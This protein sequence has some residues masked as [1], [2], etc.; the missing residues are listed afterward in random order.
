MHPVIKIVTFLLFGAAVAFGNVT[1]LG[2]G[3]ALLLV[4]Y[5]AGPA[6][7]LRLALR[8]LR[9]M[10]WFFLSIAV[11]YLLF[12]PGRLLFS[13]WPWGPTLEGLSG[14]GLRIGSLVLI[15]LAVN[16]LLRTTLRPALTSAILW[17]LGPLA[18]LGLP[19]ERVAV[20]IALTLDAIDSVQLIYR[21][22]PRDGESIDEPP[23]DLQP[24][25]LKERLW[26]IGATAQR[27]VAAV[28]E[29][30]ESVPVQSIEVPRPSNPPLWQW[31]YPLLLG[32]LFAVLRGQVSW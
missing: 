27:L 23:V 26:R 1:A 28:I 3:S 29:Q 12:T 15:V 14:G 24:K 21:H 6:E 32:T 13:Q 30:A 2:A 22:R 9:R 25:G 5:L 31:L 20:R 11:V 18:W 19:R 8:M 7:H 17:C 10:R 4:L 16:L